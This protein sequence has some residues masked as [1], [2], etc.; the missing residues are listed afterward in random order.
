MPEVRALNDEAK[1]LEVM[2][3]GSIKCAHDL[4]ERVG[5]SGIISAGGSMGT[6]LGA[7]VMRTFPV[8]LPKVMISTMASGMTRAIV[9][10]R[11]I[12]MIPSICDIAGLNA[13]TRRI[14]EN[15]ARAVAGMAHGYRPTVAS[16]KPLIAIGTLGTTENCCGIIRRSL[17][18][19]GCEVMVFHT[20]GTGGIAMDETV[21]EQDVAVVVN[22]SLIEVGDFL[23]QGLFS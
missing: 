3:K 16:D 12:V 8:G 15:G 9:G 18:E 11:D 10:T 4:H 20:Q 1:C 7:A 19:K 5:L 14:F 6:D 2:A 13:V 22:L 21:R 23:S 17:E